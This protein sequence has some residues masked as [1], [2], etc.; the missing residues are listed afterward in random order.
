MEAYTVNR[1]TE[2]TLVPSTVDIKIQ[3]LTSNVHLTDDNQLT[4]D[5]AFDKL[6]ETVEKHIKKQYDDGKIT[7]ESYAEVYLNSLVKV[8]DV[9]NSFVLE[10][11]VKNY[12][13]Q[14]IVENTKLTASRKLLIDN[15][16]NTEETRTNLTKAEIDK[17]LAATDFI[18]TQ[19]EELRIY[20][21]Q[22]YRDASVIANEQVKELQAKTKLTDTE[23]DSILNYKNNNVHSQTLLTYSKIKSEEFNNQLLSKQ[24]EKVESEKNKIDYEVSTILPASKVKLDAD[25]A[26][27]NAQEHLTETKDAA[28]AHDNNLKDAQTAVANKQIELIARQAKGFDD[29]AK[30]RLIKEQLGNWS[31]AYSVAQNDSI[32]DSVKPNPIDSVTKNLFDSLG[33]TNTKDP[34]GE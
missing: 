12:Q 5:G 10:S 33:I 29:D 27:V 3:D 23:T 24:T 17:E 13:I 34:L 9:S 25:T 7:A 11:K 19:I 21:F 2:S 22:Q 18:N 6:M 4:G 14:E 28:V 32:P 16:T 26:L 30:L 20:K 31:V 8:L 15:Q 1:E